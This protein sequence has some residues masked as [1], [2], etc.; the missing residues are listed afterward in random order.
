MTTTVLNRCPFTLSMVAGI[1][2]GAVG[3]SIYLLGRSKSSTWHQVGTVYTIKLYPI[4]G[5]PGFPVGGQDDSSS[6]PP[7]EV[8]PLGLKC[9]KLRDR[10][11]VL[12]RFTSSGSFEFVSPRSL[13]K[14]WLVKVRPTED[15]SAVLVDAPGRD[16]IKIDFPQPDQSSHVKVEI[17]RSTAAALLCCDNSV[18]K[19]FSTFLEKDNLLLACG[20]D[21]TGNLISP[22]NPHSKKSMSCGCLIILKLAVA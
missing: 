1:G 14:M 20:L 2:L 3:I 7:V 10:C 18:N 13:P 12:G 11:F 9:G 16:Q 6:S 4:K 5:L 8:T 19:W 22:R 21:S 15:Y 17:W